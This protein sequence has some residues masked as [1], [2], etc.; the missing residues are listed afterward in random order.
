MDNVLG[1]GLRKF[2]LKGKYLQKYNSNLYTHT[3]L[4][5]RNGKVSIHT[6]L[7]LD[8][9]AINIIRNFIYGSKY[10]NIILSVRTEKEP[11]SSNYPDSNLIRKLL[12]SRNNKNIVLFNQEPWPEPVP[13]FSN[14]NLVIRFGFDE[15]CEF[16]K[17]QLTE[18]IP[19]SEFGID[20][21]NP[22]YQNGTYHY[23]VNNQEHPSLNAKINII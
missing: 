6:N 19:L 8:K 13:N 1:K 21:D 18:P 17:L 4:L 2:I 22:K 23:L 11:F 7:G 9:D 16:D 12:K 14:S 20:V 5:I 15:E 10:D 3:C